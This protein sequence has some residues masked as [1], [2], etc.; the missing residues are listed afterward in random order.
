M[1]G[2]GDLHVPKGAQGGR[3]ARTWAHC[4]CRSLPPAPTRAYVWLLLAA[5]LYVWQ[6][7]WQ[8][9]NRDQVHEIAVSGSFQLPACCFDVASPFACLMH[10][11]GLWS[12]TGGF[13]ADPKLW[14]RNTLVAVV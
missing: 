6:S 4:G 10:P 9:A 13:F 2:G 14:R 7:I 5:C 11:A 12:P 8:A 1:G 3:W